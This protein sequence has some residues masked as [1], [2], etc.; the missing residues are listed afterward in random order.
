MNKYGLRFLAAILIATSLAGC[1]GLAM[2]GGPGKGGAT[3][4][5]PVKANLNASV[6]RLFNVSQTALESKRL[7]V[8]SLA[9]NQLSARVTSKFPDGQDITIVITEITPA[10][11]EVTVRVSGANAS[12]RAREI[13]DGI[14]ARL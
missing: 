8:K 13:L 4:S 11:C 7:P 10:V 6:G 12:A 1:V 14:K 9:S 2:G 5:G 3:A